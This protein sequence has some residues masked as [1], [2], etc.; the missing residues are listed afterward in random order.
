[1][2]QVYE[3]LK[4]PTSDGFK[5]VGVAVDPA[6]EQAL[7]P[8]KEDWK[9][10]SQSAL[11]GANAAPDA[12]PAQAGSFWRWFKAGAVVLFFVIGWLAYSQYQ[13]HKANVAQIQSPPSG[14]PE[15]GAS[16]KNK[17]LGYGKSHTPNKA[18]KSAT[19]NIADKAINT[20]AS[21]GFYGLKSHEKAPEKQ[22]KKPKIKDDFTADFDR[23]LSKFET[24]LKK[25]FP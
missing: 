13:T 9:A 2:N 23:D 21:D 19:D 20:P 4:D 15:I 1:M 5:F 8:S 10:T 22:A 16:P 12:T 24:D 17:G 3:P 11:S 18:D 6:I 25:E 14:L 7:A